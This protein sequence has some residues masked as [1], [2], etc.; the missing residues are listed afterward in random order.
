ML[1]GAAAALVVAAT[2]ARAQDPRRVWKLGM[3]LPST[4]PPGVPDP[5]SAASLIPAQL[6]ELGFVE[7]KNLVVDRRYA[8]AQLDRLPA[9]ARELVEARPD[10][11]VA[12]G[13]TATRAARQAT[14]SIPILF[15]GNFDPVATGTVTNLA[16]PGGNVTGVLIA[17]E[18]TLAE[19]KVELLLEAAP[20]AKRIVFLA[21]PDPAIRYQFD[22]AR[23][24]ASR[25]GVDV[26]AVEVTSGD[27]DRAFAAIAK[28]RPQALFV[29]AHTIFVR[30]R[31][32]VIE[33]ANRLRVPAI[34]EWSEHVVDGG[35]MSYGSSLKATS[36]RVA[37]VV[38]RTF[39]GT[40]P[41]D[42]PIEQPTTFR[43]VVNAG[44]ARTTGIE[45]P[46][47]LLM[48]ADEVVP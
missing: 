19:K 1:L 33:R 10:A 29:A 21:P 4:R 46:R 43:L 27:Y 32:Q 3:L 2:G 35:L 26:V 47:T 45:L 9:L 7:G 16:R 15:Y 6:G 34:Y 5:V 39:K 18:G 44:T 48:R 20:K 30:D 22:E 37:E 13:A 31:R 40:P 42:I 12:L 36:R 8:E 24:A 17:P 14:T 25:Q 28:E 38:G 23:R 11:I 41:G